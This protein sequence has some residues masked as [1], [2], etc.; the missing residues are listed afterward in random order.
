M[1]IDEAGLMWNFGQQ[2]VETFESEL[3]LFLT[4]ATTII[5]TNID[6]RDSGSDPLIVETVPQLCSVLYTAL[7]WSLGRQVLHDSYGRALTAL[8]LQLQRIVK[9]LSS[10]TINSGFAS[11]VVTSSSSSTD[12]D[13]KNVTVSTTADLSR[14]VNDCLDILRVLVALVSKFAP[15]T[16]DDEKATVLM[17]QYREQSVG[18]FEVSCRI[19][20]S[21]SQIYVNECRFIAGILLSWM[22]E[23]YGNPEMWVQETVNLESQNEQGGPFMLQ[24]SQDVKHWKQHETYDYSFLSFARGVLST[25]NK[26]TLTKECQVIG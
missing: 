16:T 2:V 12:H 25:V 13:L 20:F 26:S 24:L 17:A 3:D 1:A 23:L 19:T 10:V 15:S 9:D 5:Q 22:L 8:S 11:V 6:S 4:R 18:L 14:K 7:D 21:N